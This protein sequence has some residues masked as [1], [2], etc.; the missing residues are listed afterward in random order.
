MPPDHSDVPNLLVRNPATSVMPRP[1]RLPGR[2]GGMAAAVALLAE[3]RE[4]VGR[5]V[6]QQWSRVERAARALFGS[7]DRILKRGAFLELMEEPHDEAR[8]D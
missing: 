1:P 8:E 4:T 3:A 6:A 7:L 5:M 2:P